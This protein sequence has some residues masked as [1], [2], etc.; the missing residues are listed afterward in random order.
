[1]KKMLSLLLVIVLCLSLCACGDEN[2]PPASSTPGSSSSNGET[3][4]IT[5]ENWQEYFELTYDSNP[6]KITCDKYGEISIRSAQRLLTP[7]KKYVSWTTDMNISI[8]FLCTQGYICL[9]NYN[10]T[11]GITSSTSPI[12]H[13]PDYYGKLRL[14]KDHI[15]QG[16]Y[17]FGA[18]TP[19]SLVVGENS[20]TIESTR[21]EKMEITAI[22]GTITF[23]YFP[24]PNF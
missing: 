3:I 23:R 6:Q 8:E 9:N 15:R 11:T 17:V 4:E 20:V 21:Y 18:L 5:A 24:V 1:M 2:E 14:T 7:K 22:Q 13:M 19:E 12:R 10:P 16:A